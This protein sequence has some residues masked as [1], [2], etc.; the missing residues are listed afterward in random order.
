MGD[1]QS[2]GLSE[3]YGAVIPEKFRSKQEMFLDA[4]KK[5]PENLALACVHQPNDLFGIPSQPLDEE[6][7]HK[8]PYLRWT[9]R[10]LSA[11]VFRCAA[12]FRAAGIRPGMPFFTFNTNGAEHVISYWAL[13]DIGCIFVPINPRNLVNRAEVVHMINTALSLAPEARPVVMVSSPDLAA[14]IDEL[15]VFNH[16]I[17]IAVTSSA[18]SKG[19]IPFESLMCSGYPTVKSEEDTEPANR[20][21]DGVVLFT[22]GTTSMPK[23][24]YREHPQ[25][26]IYIHAAQCVTTEDSIVAGSSFC[27][28]LPNNHAMGHLCLVFAQTAGAAMVYPGPTFQAD[29]MLQTLTALVPTLVHALTGLKASLGHRLTHLKLV[30][31]GGAVLTPENLQ[32]CIDELGAQR[33]ENAFGMTEGLLIRSGGQSELSKIVDG[34]HVAVGWT[35]PGTAIRIAD[36]ETNQVLPRNRLGELQCSALSVSPY[37][38]GV[39]DDSFYNDKGGRLWFKTGDQAR[40]DE[41]GRLFITG[42]YKDMII[43]G[44]ENMSPTAIEAA[45]S[46][47][48]KLAALN[49]QVVALSDQ[50]AGE[51]PVAVVLGPATADIKDAIQAA[52]T[53][54]MGTLYTPDDVV[55][56][57]DLG[58]SDY[59]RTMAGK[60]QKTKLAALVKKWHD[61]EEKRNA[62]VGTEEL[63][64]EVRDI[65]AK[66]VGLDPARLS[67]DSQIG[68]FADSITVMRVRDTVRRKTGKLLSMVDMAK[69]DTISGHIALLQAQTTPIEVG[70]NR[71][72]V[73]QGPPEVG[74]MSHLTADPDLFEPTKEL[75]SRVIRPH[76]LSWEDVEDVIPAYD[77]ANMLAETRLFDSWGFKFSILFNKRSK[78]VSKTRLKCDCAFI[79]KLFQEVRS[80][81]ERLLK[82]NRMLASFLVADP[83]V[84]GSTDSLHVAIRHSK[85]LFDIIFEDGG[86]LK[87]VDELKCLAL[88][89]KDQVTYPGPLSRAVLYNIEET[90]EVGVVFCVDHATIDASTGL[91][92]NADLDK[93]LKSTSPLSEHVDY[94]LW[95]DSYHNQRT[96]LE[97]KAATKWHVKR[98]EG[99]KDHR[100]ALWPEFQMPKEADD[101]IVAS[102]EEEAVYHNFDAPEIHEFRRQHPRITANIVIKTAL[103]L[104][105]LHRNDYTH[106]L[107]AN[108]EAARTTFPFL[109]KAVEATGH[110][111]ATDVSG[112]TIQAVINFVKFDPEETVISLLERVQEDQNNLTKY[113]SAPLQEIISSLGDV[114][115]IIPE[116]IG[117]QIYNW[118]PGM[119]TTGTNP[120]ENFT[121]LNSVIRN[122]LGLSWNAGLGGRNTDTFFTS[123]RGISFD[124]EQQKTL[125]QDWEKITLW[126]LRRENWDVA[127]RGYDSSLD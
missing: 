68:E 70:E 44:G 14:S 114:G 30:M 92:F 8:Q 59:P 48:P 4:V 69:V 53:V 101:Y 73:R 60:I 110:F 28:V 93:A 45:I 61:D 72:I 47:D 50:I 9:F 58:L 35:Q 11:A 87:T 66:A 118:T 29:T 104:L 82:N 37:I 95:A 85:K 121:V 40:M 90:S 27:G 99:L 105:N 55:S 111:E 76:G 71:R 22:S 5:Y 51:V 6:T 89:Y 67:F 125:V 39:S 122:R 49:P 65:W 16:G 126:L 31:F 12:G 81:M 83:D 34:D 15:G 26:S 23:G 7:Y 10:E 116:T 56:L 17:R 38:G 46:K 21:I 18:A 20:V 1:L 19:W 94:K 86:N 52:V 75:I 2:T 57:Q 127:V 115:K 97:A 3:V 102:S 120:H 32:T 113:A 106:A 33:V 109:P 100:K 24:C 96:S 74:D 62:I 123:V 91:I 43:R 112:P 124:R 78:E 42:R 36:P 98:L 54:N 108:L 107:F 41:T 64:V 25:W 117:H 103:V 63:A 119:G 13:V 84:L 79:D 88:D 77:F 80:A